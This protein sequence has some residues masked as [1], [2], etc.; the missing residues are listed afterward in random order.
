MTVVDWI[1]CSCVSFC[2]YHNYHNYVFKRSWGDFS[3]KKNENVSLNSGDPFILL[4]VIYAGFE[5]NIGILPVTMNGFYPWFI[6]LLIAIS[7]AVKLYADD[8][9]VEY[10]V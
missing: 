2:D 7:N 10:N 9:F 1:L 6:T 5:Y 4:S 3:T 8:A